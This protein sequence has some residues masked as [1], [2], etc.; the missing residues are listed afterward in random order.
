MSVFLKRQGAHTV[1]ASMDQVMDPLKQTLVFAT[2]RCGVAVN[3]MSVYAG[4]GVPASTSVGGVFST[5][6]T[7]AGGA[8]GGGGSNGQGELGPNTSASEKK[9][10]QQHRHHR[11]NESEAVGGAPA[12]AA[13]AAAAAAAAAALGHYPAIQGQGQTSSGERDVVQRHSASNVKADSRRSKGEGGGG[14]GGGEPGGV[15]TSRGASVGAWGQTIVSRSDNRAGAASVGG[16]MLDNSMFVSS[17]VTQALSSAP[18]PPPAAHTQTQP[19]PSHIGLEYMNV[20]PR[21][22][23]Q[24]QNM[25]DLGGSGGSV[26]SAGHHA[27]VLGGTEHG[28]HQIP[29]TNFVMRGAM[30]RS[31]GNSGRDGGESTANRAIGKHCDSTGSSPLEGGLS[32]DSSPS[33]GGSGHHV[34]GDSG[35]GGDAAMLSGMF[36]NM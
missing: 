12:A 25:F 16:I 26:D 13:S 3:V 19:M 9:Q 14:G 27:F 30:G 24:P 7:S 22:Q 4:K 29:A 28:S 23:H 36:V 34:S 11:G 20:M 6:T 2:T 5:T 33:R 32:S 10:Q 17:S 18:A 1:A 15:R 31:G 35:D 8:D 21:H